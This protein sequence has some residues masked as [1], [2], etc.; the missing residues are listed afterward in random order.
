[1]RKNR[2]II[3]YFC[4][5]FL[6]LICGITM[7]SAT[8]SALEVNAAGNSPITSISGT[9]YHTHTVSQSIIGSPT[10]YTESKYKSTGIK[11][12]APNNKG[13]TTSGTSI[14]VDATSF[15]VDFTGANAMYMPSSVY[16]NIC[17]TTHYRFEIISSSG[18][19]SWYIDYSVDISEEPYE[20]VFNVNGSKTIKTDT[21]GTDCINFQPTEL[22]SRLVSLYNGSFTW[23]LTREYT[24]LKYDTTNSIYAMYESK[25]TLSGTL[26]LDSYTPSLIAKGYTNGSTITSG[27][28]VNQRVTFTASDTNFDRIYYKIPGYSYYLTTYSNTYTSTAVNGWWYVY[29]VDDVGNKTSEFSFYYDATKPTG[30]ISSN[31]TTVASGS[32]VSKSL[33]YTATDSGSGIKQIYYKSPV[34]SSYQAYSAG[35]IIPATAGDGWYY[36]Y[37][38]DNAGNQ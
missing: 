9:E 18:Y 30:S 21:E 25:S 10:N 35:T 33:A 29:A 28:Y 5:S 20:R 24:W 3:K 31:G 34:S 4:V 38:V 11:V 15:Y 22:G 2:N 13:T 12:Y 1:M 36:F 23:K 37:S 16:E 26:L 7:L 19:T 14:N 27:S 6:T 17:Y 8:G 32:Y